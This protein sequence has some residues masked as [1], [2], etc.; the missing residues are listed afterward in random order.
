MIKGGHKMFYF[1]RRA[2]ETAEKTSFVCSGV[3]RNKQ[4]GF[5]PF[6]AMDGRRPEGS[7]LTL[8]LPDWRIDLEHC[9]VQKNYE[10][11]MMHGVTNGESLGFKTE[12]RGKG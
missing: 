4:K 1:H 8:Y 11:S 2:T 5:S 6:G 10:P 3:H 12:G 9:Q 7:R